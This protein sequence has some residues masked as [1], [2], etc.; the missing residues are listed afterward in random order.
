[1]K[2]F[3]YKKFLTNNWN[4]F[5]HRKALEDILKK[6]PEYNKDCQSVNS[7][8]MK[9]LDDNHMEF[10]VKYTDNNGIDHTETFSFNEKGQK[11]DQ[12]EKGEKGDRGEKG[13]KG[14]VGS[15]GADGKSATIQVGSTQ[16]ISPTEPASVE[17]SGTETNAVLNFKIPQGEKGDTG[18]KGDPGPQGPKG[19]Q[20]EP[21]TLIYQNKPV[22]F[23][24][25]IN[26]L[27]GTSQKGITVTKNNNIT[28]ATPEWFDTLDDL[29]LKVGD[30]I[31]YSALIKNATSPVHCEVQFYTDDDK[32][33]SNVEGNDVTNGYTSVT[34]TIPENTCKMLHVIRQENRSSD[35]TLTVFKEKLELGEY[36]TDWLPSM[37]DFSNVIQKRTLSQD[38]LTNAVLSSHISGF[39][40]G[41]FTYEYLPY[42]LT[43]GVQWQNEKIFLSANFTNLDF[44]SLGSLNFT[45]TSNI[46][47]QVTFSSSMTIITDNDTITVP[48]Y[49]E[50]NTDKTI[51]V[52]IY[53]GCTNVVHN[54][55][56]T[57]CT[58]FI[59]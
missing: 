34:T 4:D 40:N 30:T 25:N 59:H 24:G 12:G 36:I 2:D 13:D 35:V 50:V 32:W 11:G 41:K 6:V 54:L 16:T 44:S 43:N 48:V 42:L 7:I 37:R 52:T 28:T 19:P 49:V 57:N 38:Q 39:N 23:V 3:N 18:P 20:G 46:N 22:M 53:T 5:V 15:S 45:T 47:N 29:D 51:S 56:T 31:T 17:N 9:Q 21:G 1:M 55:G 27:A 26:Y 8:E 33:I 14:D 10:I 58:I